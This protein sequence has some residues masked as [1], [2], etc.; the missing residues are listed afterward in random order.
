MPVADGADRGEVREV[1]AD[2]VDDIDI[3]EDLH[4]LA[5]GS[6]Q[7]VGRDGVVGDDHQ[8]ED[9]LPA[10]DDVGGLQPLGMQPP[11]VGQQQLL[12]LVGCEAR[13]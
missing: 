10:V 8:A 3:V 7:Q 1:R 11:H 5:L 12:E 6:T 9:V 4:A 13:L 2:H